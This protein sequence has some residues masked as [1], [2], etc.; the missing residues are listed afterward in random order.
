MSG[1]V[2]TSF[3]LLLLAAC[4]LGALMHRVPKRPCPNCGR[5]T[6]TQARRCRHCRYTFGDV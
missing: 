6:P 3:F 4:V 5:E 1:T 2:Y